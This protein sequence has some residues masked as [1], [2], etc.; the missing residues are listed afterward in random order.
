MVII[1]DVTYPFSSAPQALEALGKVPEIPDFLKIHGPYTTSEKGVGIRNIAVWEF[2]EGR[3]KDAA[4]AITKRFLTFMMV[5][6]Y[7]WDMNPF[8]EENESTKLM[9]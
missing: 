6:G 2:P 8:Y 7:S 1:T 4:D 9:E 3:F 5:P